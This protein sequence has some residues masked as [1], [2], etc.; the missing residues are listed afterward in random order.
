MLAVCF[1]AELWAQNE[2][3]VSSSIQPNEVGVG[4]A[5]IVQLSV[6]TDASGPS[7]SDPRLVL[8]PELRASQPSVSTQTQ[9]SFINGRL[10]RRSGFTATWQVV[11]SRE[12]VFGIA[13]PSA[14]WNGRRI[15]G[16][17]L[18]VKVHA[19]G[20]PG[21]PG[22]R[23]PVPSTPNPF[24]PF[25]M[26]PR[27][28]NFFDQPEVEERQAEPQVDPEIAID[29]P[30]DSKVFLRSTIDKREPVVGEQVTLTVYVY[31]RVG[32]VEYTDA[33]EPSLPDFYRRELLQHGV[34]PETKRITLNGVGWLVKPIFK[35]ALFP[36]RAGEIDIGPMQLTL[37]S[38]SLGL[39]QAVRASQTL[40]LHVS[41]P[42]AAGR[43]VGY[44]MGD[45]GAY[46]LSATVDPRTTEV[47]GAIGVTI[48]LG[49]VGNVPN[50]IRV[51]LS[52]SFEWL[53]PQAR[54]N[55]EIENGKIRGSRTFTYV[56]RPKTPGALELGTVSLPF[57][58][59][60]TKSYETARAVLGKVQV[61]DKAGGLTKDPTA[62]HD[63]WSALGA[64]RAE[65]KPCSHGRAPWT[66]KLLYWL[67]L[68]GL[69][70]AVVVGSL[71][72]RG[73]KRM[74]A[75]MAA[76]RAGAERGIEKALS[77]ARDARKKGDRMQ[78][79]GALDRA[80]Y[81]A[82]ERATGLRA[83]ALLQSELPR[84]LEERH[85]HA[86]LAAE[87]GQ[88]LSAIESLRF[89]PDGGPDA[90]DLVDRAAAVIRRLARVTPG[91]KKS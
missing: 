76:R 7:A 38:R 16:N 34:E 33:H 91:G 6:S 63:P 84:A 52:S 21:T 68:I 26:F 11:A 25:G 77:D 18:R 59:P 48:V 39:Q 74:R 50:A 47:G 46:T 8:P 12:G 82:I 17:A 83:R 45:V 49:G 20:A 24:D 43:P 66:D 42:P 29:Q 14:S 28:P 61:A 4:E 35:V 23:Q 3:Q 69:P 86:D 72:S 1:P 57:W 62:L 89:V 80:L 71:G 64:P 73:M 13:A 75:E 27:F 22:R 2:P 70:V 30:L 58:N 78:I 5:F 51:P 81:L 88:L 60:N 90:G 85:V 37:N 40:R 36:L 53:E 10:S 15:Q 56:V 31:Q 41:E 54:E 65:L 19:A 44:Q 79:A 32:M 9:I 67:G 55:I 87:V